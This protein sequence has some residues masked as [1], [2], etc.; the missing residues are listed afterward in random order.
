MTDNSLTICH[1][2]TNG[3]NP[4]KLYVKLNSLLMHGVS[5]TYNLDT[6][7][8]L[9]RLSERGEKL[10]GYDEHLREWINSNKD[11]INEL[12][13]RLDEP[14]KGM[15]GFQNSRF[16]VTSS[17]IIDL[18]T[19]TPQK[20]VEIDDSIYAEIRSAFI[21]VAAMLRGN[22]TTFINNIDIYIH[23]PRLSQTKINWSSNSDYEAA[24]NIL[25]KKYSKHVEV[26]NT[27]IIHIKVNKSDNIEVKKLCAAILIALM[28]PE[29]FKYYSANHEEAVS[30][31][32]NGV[33]STESGE[34]SMLGILTQ[35]VRTENINTIHNAIGVIDIMQAIQNAYKKLD[36]R[37]YD[38][39]TTINRLNKTIEM[40]HNPSRYFRLDPKCILFIDDI[41]TS[42]RQGKLGAFDEAIEF[43]DRQREGAKITELC[44]IIDK[45]LN[46]TFPGS[47]I[48]NAEGIN[49]SE[50][51]LLFM[52][53]RYPADS[54][55]DINS[56]TIYVCRRVLERFNSLGINV[57]S[58]FIIADRNYKAS[59]M[60]NTAYG[61]AYTTFLWCQDD[62]DFS[63]SIPEICSVIESYN[64]K[65]EVQEALIGEHGEHKEEEQGEEY[66]ALMGEHGEEEQGV[67]EEYGD[68]AVYSI[69][70]SSIRRFSGL[71]GMWRF[72]IRTHF[73]RAICFN[74]PPYIMQGED[75]ITT[76]FYNN[77]YA[78][79]FGNIVDLDTDA[80]LPPTIDNEKDDTCVCYMYMEASNRYNDKS[81]EKIEKEVFKESMKYLLSLGK[82][83]EEK[84]KD[85]W[86]V[87][88]MTH[89]RNVNGLP[90]HLS[91]IDIDDYERRLEANI[92][93]FD[94]VNAFH[95]FTDRQGKD[96]KP[97][98]SFAAQRPTEA[99][100]EEYAERLSKVGVTVVPREAVLNSDTGEVR[101]GGRKYSADEW[102]ARIKTD[103]LSSLG[104]YRKQIRENVEADEDK[105]DDVDITKPRLHF[106]GGA[107]RNR[108]MII[109]IMCL[110]IAL[111]IVVIICIV[112]RSRSSDVTETTIHNTP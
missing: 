31:S 73:A 78:S 48:T 6:I 35:A 69:T 34:I 64:V 46:V 80:L 63:C 58:R 14:L 5:R 74:N 18:F 100:V 9:I 91:G 4:Y 21:L 15:V 2:L 62:D 71:C 50:L 75:K 109:L 44:D 98:Y 20:G 108:T 92:E 97:F 67:Q 112:L 83:D 76:E 7:D 93:L 47:F 85:R 79:V 33:S 103:I 102:N 54:S 1:L 24:L 65:E 19:P 99:E 42:I 16:N 45:A 12:I 17:E 61:Y 86:G 96:M 8:L 101:Y 25:K 95:T 66:E 106:Y 13:R 94:A 59:I 36:S 39:Q 51:H 28:V 11:R 88:H 87:R 82:S 53:D 52:V 77:T 70:A 37:D 60:R 38:E 41:E 22:D 72:L 107:S 3:T 43:F 104:A 90:E 56:D 110:L 10:K 30:V 105:Y 57:T 26:I 111:I 32:I 81:N 29:C 84:T 55:F 68:K 89:K 23:T 27:N 40:G 49:L